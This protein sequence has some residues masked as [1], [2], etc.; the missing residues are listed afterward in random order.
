MIAYCKDVNKRL[1][2]VFELCIWVIFAIAYIYSI[3][4]FAGFWDEPSAKLVSWLSLLISLLIFYLYKKAP[5]LVLFGLSFVLL[6]YTIVS[7]FGLG[8]IYYLLG[9]EHM[10]QYDWYILRFLHSDQYVRSVLLSIIAIQSYTMAAC[11]GSSQCSK[12]R[13]TKQAPRLETQEI[14][15]TLIVHTGLLFLAVAIIYFFMQITTGRISLT[16]DYVVYFET[17]V[18]DNSLHSF[19]LIIY[20]AGI[21]YVV[22]AGTSSRLKLGLCLFAIIA[23]LMFTIGSRSGV[24]YAGMACIGVSRYRKIRIHP[25]LILSIILLIFIFLPLISSTRLGGLKGGIH[26]SSFSFTD[27]FVE[28]GMQ[29]R[30]NVYILEDFASGTRDYLNGLSYYNPLINIL[31]N[32]VPWVSLRLGEVSDFNFSERFPGYGFSQVTESYANFGLIGVISFFSLMG[33]WVAKIE[34]A[35]LRPPELALL[36]SIVLILI[37]ASRNRFAF[38]FGQVL[39]MCVLYWGLKWLSKS[40]LLR[41]ERLPNPHRKIH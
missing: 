23:I 13:Q 21:A 3:L 33:Y 40:S 4:A 17:V 5:N 10:S 8:T 18:T 34:T 25:L 1:P 19:I 2:C 31:D 9:P 22:S 38:V 15:S 28:T 7:Q 12:P 37:N 41:K 6:L 20:G 32:L 27:A 29:I 24:I 14:E 26:A 36:S 35:V 16:Q 30:L 11:L 39:I